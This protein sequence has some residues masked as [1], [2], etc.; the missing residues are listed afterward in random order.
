MAYGVDIEPENWTPIQNHVFA[1]SLSS[2]EKRHSAA[3]YLYLYDRAYHSPSK[4]IPA[5]VAE[6]ASLTGIDA[7]TANKCLAELRQKELIRQVR[8]GIKHSKAKT[9]RPVW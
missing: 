8:Q 9:R 2:L 5:T 1:D 3:L 7:R 4:R 6:L